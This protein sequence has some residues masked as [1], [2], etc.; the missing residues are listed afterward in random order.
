MIS[1]SSLQLR[2][3]KALFAGALIAVAAVPAHAQATDGRWQPWLGCWSPDGTTTVDVGGSSFPLVCVNPVAGSP[4]VAIAT[5]ANKQVMHLELINATGQRVAKTVDNCPGWESATWSHDGNRLMMRSEFTCANSTVVKGSSI[6][7][8]SP[9]GDWLQIQGSTIGANSG[10]RVVRYHPSS[11]KLANGTVLADSAVVRVVDAPEMGF[12][13]RS[14]RTAAGGTVANLD[15]LID[16]AKQVDPAVS[17]AWLTETSQ[18]LRLNAKQLTLLAD[19][20]LPAPMIDLLVAMSYPERFALQPNSNRRVDDRAYAG[21]A[22]SSGRMR[23]D[24]DCGYGDRMLMYGYYGNSCYPG[25]YGS[26]AYGGYG[27]GNRYGYLSSPYDYNQYYYGQQPII[28]ITRGS[29]GGPAGPARGRAVKGQGYT[30]SSGSSGSSSG[31]SEPRTTSSGSSTT[32]G[33][34]GS[35]SSGKSTPPAS[36]GTSGGDTGRTAKTRPPGGSN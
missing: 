20:G 11:V 7:A 32:T 14:M 6:F 25:F 4:A 28:I 21:T 30:R 8:F 12:A 1:I 31:S 3:T 5:I 18:S 33:G 36:T 22:A 17:Q 34:S 10:S 2:A 35:G 29:D 24:W 16:V 26:S 13:V 27:F 15:A 23:D 19:R 9:D